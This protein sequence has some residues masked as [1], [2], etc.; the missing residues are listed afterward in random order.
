MSVENL[1]ALLREAR[2]RVKYSPENDEGDTLLERIDAALLAFDKPV[3]I[4][5]EPDPN[6]QPLEFAD[7]GKLTL[8][9]GY[10]PSP[11]T[12]YPWVWSVIGK[13][14]LRG[15]C[16]PTGE[17]AKVEVLRAAKELA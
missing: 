6:K 3:D 10:Y 15:G 5:W 9:V 14:Y 4:V 7:F 16:S 13:A 12:T 17:E 1:V 11:T 2:P 8:T